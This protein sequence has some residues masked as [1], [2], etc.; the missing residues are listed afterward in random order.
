[1]LGAFIDGLGALRVTAEV[2]G[3][4]ATF[5]FGIDGARAGNVASGA[6]ALDMRNRSK[7]GR[8]NRSKT[9]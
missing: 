3:G 7:P 8:R 9:I 6:V 5:G 1:M 2:Q 4:R